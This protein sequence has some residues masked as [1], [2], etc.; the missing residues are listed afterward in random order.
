MA[1]QIALN[2]F[3]FVE[4]SLWKTTSIEFPELMM[5]FGLLEPQYF[6]SKV[7]VENQKPDAKEI[8]TK[9]YVQEEWFSTSKLSNVSLI[10]FPEATSRFQVWQCEIT[11]MM[12]WLVTV[13]VQILTAYLPRLYCRGNW[14]DSLETGS[15]LIFHTVNNLWLEYHLN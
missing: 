9:S 14:R 6:S 1:S 8:W 4:P 5:G 11:I 7:E 10:L 13:L 15:L 3:P 2:P 12:G